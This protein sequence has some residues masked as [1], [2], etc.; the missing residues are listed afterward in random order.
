VE[1][2]TMVRERQTLDELLVPESGEHARVL[3]RFLARVMWAKAA[4]WPLHT[5]RLHRIATML[6]LPV[7]DV[8]EAA[9]EEQEAKRADCAVLAAQIDGPRERREAYAVGCVLAADGG[10][11]DDERT[12]L[13]EFATGAGI[14]PGEAR[15]ILDE[16][17][18]AVRRRSK[19]SA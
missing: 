16:A 8:R 14:G 11:G 9:L 18:A 19:R 3:A 2:A 1:A 5:H 6:D 17:R 12:V 10:L 7:D 15:A 4:G 13:S